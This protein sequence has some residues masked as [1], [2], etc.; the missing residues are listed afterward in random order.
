[1]ASKA[2]KAS[3]IIGGSISGAFKS[4]MGSTKSG[5]QAIGAEIVNIERRQR[6]MS[7]SIDVFGRQGRS[8]DGL[9]RK[10]ADL[11]RDADRLR[12][13]QDRLAR[14]NDR[15]EANRAK[16]QEIGGALRGSVTTLGVV[17][18]AAFL[19]VRQA[20]AFE[21]AMLGV[22]KQVDGARDASGRLTPVYFQ[23]AEQ[24]RKLGHELP[25]ATNEIADMV[26]AG[27]RMGIARD[28]LIGFTRNAAMM[29]TAFEM[30]AAELAD[31][32]GKIAGIFKIPIPAIGELG[33]AINKLDDNA[34]AKGSD[35]I[36][37]MQGDLAGAAATMGLSAKNAAALASTFLHL[38]E[39]AERADTA[40]AGMMRQLQVAKM[41]PKRFQI[42]V[43]MLG[44]TAEQLQKGMIDDPQAMILDVLGRIKSLP[45]G[46]Q[47]EAVTRLFGKDWGGAIAKL[48]NGVDEYRRQLDLANGEAA[49]GSMSRE[50]E[51][52]MQTMSA[53]WRVTKNRISDVS[54]AIGSALLPSITKLMESA[55]PVVERMAEWSKENPGLIRGTVGAAL[56]VT[57][58]RVG[59][60]ALRY[61]VVAVK[62]P[63][64]STMGFIA[65]WRATGPLASMGKFGP[66]ALKA[67]TAFRTI[68]TAVAAI[69]GG[70]ITIAVA[71]LTAGALVV[72]KYWEPIKAW[73]G[74][75]LDG[76]RASIGPAF[77]QLGAAMAPLKPAWD[78]I[79]GAIGTA[80][81]WVTKLLEPVNMTS[82]EL[83]AAGESGRKFG[84]IIGDV[85]GT[86]FSV[87]GGVV[88]T[89]VLLGTKIGE[90]A[91][92]ITTFFRPAFEWLKDAFDK[93]LG[94]I[95]DKIDGFRSILSVA[96]VELGQLTRMG[97]GGIG[98]AARIAFAAVTNDSSVLMDRKRELA[99]AYGL[100]GRPGAPGRPGEPGQP[101][102]PGKAGFAG[103]AGMPG[104]PGA[105]GM[106]G[107]P[108]R[109]GAAGQPGA[110]GKA[111]EPGRPGLPGRPAPFSA[112]APARGRPAPPAP[113][114]VVRGAAAATTVQ[115]TNH[116]TIVQQPGE[117]SESIARQVAR[118]IKR[119]DGQDRRG[120]LTDAAA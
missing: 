8:V 5:L 74:G 33:D 14:A 40:A 98:D 39:S 34:I 29:S 30:P 17:A 81:D 100:P 84:T 80:W 97:G 23:M 120:S 75:A 11:A 16:R 110:P 50:F 76:I 43:Q 21:D 57:G 54:V 24:I 92:A 12:V 63:F 49:K 118:H 51:A 79:S 10:Y 111:G 86:A 42:G 94:W 106:A 93:S 101:G 7:R 53:Q 38:G 60:H 18:G 72:R 2:L 113:P 116:F 102:A 36:R 19:P 48:A 103:L 55:G 73:I 58:L 95:I 44:M 78:A 64:L 41:N 70:P 15:V 22:A 27:S 4:A 35:I 119:Q 32:M 85:M 69:G 67:T 56:A 59:F 104:Q 37:V 46:Q 26:A 115:Q 82:E 88:D 109:P 1:M 87:I 28:E 96:G 3:V 99:A 62:A 47:M 91:A 108:G 13:A 45:V 25:M 20:V 83:A 9:R 65:K 6:L 107:L 31:S 105:A 89:V 117:S 90:T 61:A 52:R 71:A 112:I 66:A 68:G 114:I 77:E